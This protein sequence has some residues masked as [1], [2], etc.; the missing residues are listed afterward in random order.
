MPFKAAI[1]DKDNSRYV[2]T[3]AAGACASAAYITLEAL[4]N[5]PVYA[6]E[7]FKRLFTFEQALFT[8]ETSSVEVSSASV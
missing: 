5:D 7:F 6:C 8:S 2:F 3:F 1:Y 4:N